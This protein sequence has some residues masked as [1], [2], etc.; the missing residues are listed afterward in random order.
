MRY[1]FCLKRNK[2]NLQIR[3]KAYKSPL[4]SKVFDKILSFFRPNAGI[5]GNPEGTWTDLGPSATTG[6]SI[7]ENNANTI[8]TFYACRRVISEDCAKLPLRFFTEKQEGDALV[9]TP[10]SDSLTRVLSL[11]PNDRI[12]Y[13]DFWSTMIDWTCGLGWA[14]AERQYNFS[15]ELIGLYPIHPSRVQILKNKSG[16]FTFKIFNDNGTYSNISESNMFHV[17]AVTIDGYV[18]YNVIQL[19]QNTLSRSNSTDRY[20]RHFFENNGR[21]VGALVTDETLSPKAR[22]N[23]KRDWQLCYGGPINAGR[24]AVLDEGLKYQSFTS[25][26]KDL[27]FT[28]QWK[29]NRAQVCEWMRVNPRKVGVESSAKGWATLDAEETDHLQSCLMPW[30]M[31]YSQQIRRQLMPREIYADE[32]KCEFDVQAMLLGDL[33]TRAEMNEKYLMN[34]IKTPNEVRVEIGLN[35]SSDTGMDSRYIQGAMIP[36]G[37]A[38]K[39]QAQKA[40]ASP[41]GNNPSGK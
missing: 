16:T 8:S 13:F 10:F 29:F 23:I 5:T 27:E 33:K 41:D 2:N 18:G 20:A 21:P 36:I 40:I 37:M 1:L 6:G 30:L 25:P 11:A 12:T 4:M 31:R 22:E 38:G 19:M 7:S 39:L 17:P 9:K 35:P 3:K 34:G 28:E 26:F 15:G 32:V 24:T 14:F